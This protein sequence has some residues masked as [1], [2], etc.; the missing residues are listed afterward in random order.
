M[1]TPTWETSTGAL[2][3]LL[4]GGGIINKADVYTVTLP[5][6]QVLRWSGS[7]VAMTVHSNLFAIG[8][9]I[10]RNRMRWVVGVETSTLDLTLTDIAGTSI[11]GVP[12]YAFARARGFFGAW[13]L[14]ERV[15]WGGADSGPVGALHWFS[16]RVAECEVDRYAAR[17]TARSATELLDVQ[18]PRD[19][20]QP[21]CLNTLGDALCGVNLATAT[22][23][24][25]AG[26]ASTADRTTF[27]HSL[28]QAAGWGDLGVLTMTSGANTGLRRTVRKHTGTTLQ[29]LQPWPF[30]VASGDTF[31]LRAGCDKTQAT[32]TSKF[33][34]LAR[35]RGMPYIP[36]AETVT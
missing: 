27:N 35:F 22:A 1:R 5:T 24:G 33:A 26:S 12:L 28:A 7:D 18:V 29:V 6:G 9:G 8:P 3:A 30:A 19:V 4:N 11:N 34:N 15:F 21:G 14:L 16:G 25:A 36:V 32:C 10:V 2:A 31:T 17:I 20:Y 23:S 13:V